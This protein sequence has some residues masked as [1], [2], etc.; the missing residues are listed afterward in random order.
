MN[1]CKHALRNTKWLL[2]LLTCLF[3][4]TLLG[5]TLRY[6]NAEKSEL[7][8]LNLEEE[9]KGFL[10][11]QGSLINQTGKEDYKIVGMTRDELGQVHVRFQQTLN[12]LKAYGSFLTVHVNEDTMEV[13]GV[14]GT[15]KDSNKDVDPKLDGDAA[16]EKA[17]STLGLTDVKLIGK[18]E[19]CYVSVPVE[20]KRKSLNGARDQEMAHL[21]YMQEVTYTDDVGPQ[22][23]KLFA[24]ADSGLPLAQHHQHMYIK[25]RRAHDAQNGFGLP[26]LLVRTE[27]AAPTGDAVV[28]AA[29]DFSGITYDYYNSIHGRDSWDNL[30]SIMRSSVHVGTNYNNAFWNG[31]QAA[32]GDG[33]YNFFQ[34]LALD[35]DVVAHEITHG[36][37]QASGLIYAG[38][39]AALHEHMSDTF[40][41][42]VDAFI[43]GGVNANTWKVGDVAFTPGTAGDALRYM[44]NPTLD[45]ISTDYYPNLQGQAHRDAGVGNLAFYLLSAGGTHPTGA[46]T[47]AVNGIGINDA[48]RIWYRALTVYIGSYANP[49]YPELCAA[50]LLAAG[51]LFG[52]L[53]TQVFSVSNAWAAVG[54][55]SN[56]NIILLN[57]LSMPAGFWASVS[58]PLPANI[59]RISFHSLLGTG[60]PDLYTDLGAPPTFG[61]FLCSSTN[62]GTGEDCYHPSPAA[63]TWWAGFYANTA[64]NNVATLIIY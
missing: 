43:N 61:N 54:V 30:G 44:D 11:D 15:A 41:A 1:A 56:G 8:G 22:R 62:P 25:D 3:A 9:T 59:C 58:T 4:P 60:N 6:E 14:S 48:A 20:K 17:I 2:C 27:G 24:D 5:Q 7:P 10:R 64:F 46:T 21:A 34:P 42:T 13:L 37:S 45:G 19:L 63:G 12:G 33:D 28:N 16:I 29:Y 32:Y 31:T 26:G 49:G 38:V 23:D 35:L 50:T 51:D 36:V 39:S 40:A 53:S 57:W 18:P 47:V 55:C 52:P